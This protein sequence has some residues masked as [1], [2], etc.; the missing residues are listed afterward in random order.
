M[1]VVRIEGT[2][3][4][5]RQGKHAPRKNTKHTK[6]VRYVAVKRTKNIRQEEGGQANP[7]FNLGDGQHQH[8]HYLPTKQ[9]ASNPDANLPSYNPNLKL[10]I[11]YSLCIQNYYPDG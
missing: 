10:T 4:K 9:P 3:V 8:S 6:H 7:A 1:H 5:L 11:Y 2:L